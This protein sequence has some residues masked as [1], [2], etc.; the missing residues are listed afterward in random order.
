MSA[1]DRTRLGLGARA[2]AKAD[3]ATVASISATE[4]N[5]A[6]NDGYSR[7]WSLLANA[8]DG[9]PLTEV[10]EDIVTVQGTETYAFST[11][12]T[13]PLKIMRVMER[14]SVD[15]YKRV[16]LF[17]YDDLPYLKSPRG[18]VNIRVYGVRD[19][20]TLDTDGEAID[21][22]IPKGW[23]EYIVLHAGL[24]F[25][26]KEDSNIKAFRDSIQELKEEIISTIEPRDLG[27]APSIA[28]ISRWR[29]SVLPFGASGVHSVMRYRM[30]G[31]LLRLAE[32]DRLF[33][34]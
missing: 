25:L 26:R 22:R 5:D 34:R 1:P 20:K 31:N 6:V 12:G 9:N 18:D 2:L 27:E 4:K 3:M 15:D 11:K 32:D 23:D 16:R 21:I 19:L 10:L 30:E 24:S 8:G 14:N 29:P 28:D 33:F 7:L 13:T 17:D